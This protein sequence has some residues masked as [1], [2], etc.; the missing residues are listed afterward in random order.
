MR[1]L[2][3]FVLGLAVFLPAIV[4]RDLWA[5]DETRHAEVAAEM[6]RS[7][8]WLVPHL[9]GENYPDKPA[10]QFWAMA[11]SMRATGGPSEWAARL[12][13]VLFSAGILAL[14]AALARKLFDARVATLAVLVLASA[15][16]FLW[17]SQRVAI[18]LPSTFFCLLA[19]TFWV[20][21]QR[22]E[23]SD[24]KNG[25][26]LFA[27]LGLALLTKGPPA[28]LTPVLAIAGHAIFTKSGARLR[29]G[30]FLAPLP[31]MFAIP[32]AWAIPAY[33][34][35]GPQFG[36]DLL[37]GQWAKRIA[38]ETAHANP[39]WYYL[40][41]FTAEFLPWTP[42]LV[43]GLWLLWKKRTS[44]SP[45]ARA[46]L[47]AWIGI[48]FVVFSCFKGKRGNYLLPIYPAAAIASALA[49]VDVSVVATWLRR[50]LLALA[51]ILVVAGLGAFVAPF[52]EKVKEL[53]LEG[54]EPA[55]FAAGAALVAIGGFAALRL[56]HELANGARALA[57]G[58]LAFVP[59]AGLVVL[60]VL[61][62]EKSDRPIADA[63]VER[64]RG[65][66]SSE[67]PFIPFYRCG[68]EAVRFYSG[69]ACVEVG[70]GD[71]FRTM[72]ASPAVKLAVVKPKD[73]KK[74]FDVL[75][76]DVE[77]VEPPRAEVVVLVKP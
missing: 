36:N 18:D 41:D 6:V 31:L 68:P 21:Q 33:R 34:A 54:V 44:A 62:A 67:I 11:L 56:R 61:D 58:L 49:L 52:T 24:A 65:A 16:Q 2:A 32:L 53:A 43:A 1:P 15:A 40:Q 72:L 46:L 60:P 70:D 17:L 63:L 39:P 35:G 73:R 47:L 30:A 3:A 42:A 74:F 7:G 26:G 22:G 77:L 10:L 20:R 64:A 71:V 9:N 19:I 75:P 55:A 27:A 5:P 66:A 12:P 45:D 29:R 25:L 76:D 69:L 59:L 13:F 57:A 28:V 50:A 8:D 23:G 14:T 48:T 51:C 4:R 38:S 37:F